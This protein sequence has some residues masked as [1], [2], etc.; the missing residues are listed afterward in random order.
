MR[1]LTLI[2]SVIA[3][4]AV[5]GCRDLSF[6]PAGSYTQ[7]DLV[8]EGGRSGEWASLLIPLLTV[9]QDYFVTTEPLFQIASVLSEPPPDPSTTKNIVLCGVLDPSSAVGGR[10]AFLLGD[11]GV[12]RVMKGE[13]SILKRENVPQPGQL[14]L[15]VTAPTDAALRKVLAERGEE[16]PEIIDASCRERLRK[17]LLSSKR[18]GLT[19][20]LRRHWGFSIEIPTLYTLYNESE[21]PPGVELH[22]DSPPRVLGVFWTEWDHVPTLYNTQELFEFRAK[23]VERKY[24]GD[25]MDPNRARYSYV[26]LGPYTAIRMCGYWFNDRYSLA[27]GYF[28]TYFIW[29][30]EEKLLWAVDCLV[31]APGREKTSLVR[32]LHALAETFH[33]D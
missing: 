15:I 12:E 20:R 16:I 31:Y 22:R 21:D 26:R 24:D 2:L 4:L 3:V 6:P 9:E 33:Y 19:E 5:G 10:I 17:G 30:K 27:G 7:I 18:A 23:Y 1:A 8:V 14:T 11:A 25:Q 32:E 29:D 13:A 28:E